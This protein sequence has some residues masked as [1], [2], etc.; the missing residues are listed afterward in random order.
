MRRASSLAVA[1]VLAVAG[2]AAGG[3]NRSYLVPI[4]EACPGSGNCFPPKLASTYSFESAILY[5]SPKPYSGPKKL[6]VM[7][8]IK[9]LKDASGNLVTGQV[10]LRIPASRITLLG[11]L[12]LGTIGD[13]N[14]IAAEQIYK[15]D[16]KNGSGRQAFTTPDVTPAHGL[17]ANAFESPVLYD[18]DGNPL[19]STGTQSKP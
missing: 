18:P 12:N 6:A 1:L 14:P 16:V 11:S 3:L 5:S 10:Q 9:G 19:A 8:A 17:T 4:Y 13:N 15:V 2:T 7:V